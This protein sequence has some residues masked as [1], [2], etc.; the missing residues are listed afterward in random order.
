M[1]IIQERILESFFYEGRLIPSKIRSNVHQNI[2]KEI[3][4]LISIDINIKNKIWLIMNNR[5]S[6]PKC[7]CGKEAVWSNEKKGYSDFCSHICAMKSNKTK[8]KKKKIYLN[9]KNKSLSNLLTAKSPKKELSEEEIIKKR[10][11]SNEKRKETIFKRYGVTNIMHLKEFSD[12]Q[13]ATMIKKYGVSKPLQN[14]KI[15]EKQ[16]ETIKTIYGV[17]NVSKSGEVQ[18]KKRKSIISTYG[19]H[20]TLTSEVQEKTKKTCNNKYGVENPMQNDTV[21]S[22]QRSSMLKAYGVLYPLQNKEINQKQRSTTQSRYGYPNIFKSPIILNKRKDDFLEKLFTGDRLQEKVIPMFKRDDYLKA[23]G[24]RYLW[25]CTTC[26][27][28]FEDDINNGSIPRCPTCFPS[29][30]SIGEKELF[31]FVNS[32]VPAEEN[33]RLILGKKELDIFIPSKNIGIEYNGLYYHAELASKRDGKYHIKKY[34]ECIE[35]NIDPIFIFED[36]WKCKQPIVESIIKARLSIFSIKIGARK[37]YIKDLTFIEQKTFFTANHIQGY[38]PSSIAYGLVYNDEIVFAMSFAKSR[39]NKKY[40]FELMRMATKIGLKVQGGSSRLL[41]K[42]KVEHKGIKLISYC[43][44]RLFTGKG[45]EEIGFKKIK[46]SP[47]NYYYMYRYLS[48]E[49]RIKY[50]KH[51]LPSLLQVFNSELTEW[52]NMQLNGYDRIWDCGNMVFELTT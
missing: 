35:K 29:N 46:C 37:C 13:E 36:E 1:R 51:K 23:K 16:K 42:F 7:E 49:S 32:I 6:E 11:I 17:D 2:I 45:Y 43:D 50:Q 25:K 38:A 52:E 19:K 48:R 20:Y 22:K 34:E 4:A 9:N 3:H 10:N 14:K 5:T 28:E 30:S 33:N 18:E 26:T 47:P 8:D 15:K 40:D 21:S 24:Y 31:T 41:N 12:K 44:K 27:T 39:F